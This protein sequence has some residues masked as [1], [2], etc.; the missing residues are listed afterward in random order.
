MTDATNSA[1]EVDAVRQLRGVVLDIEQRFNARIQTLEDEND[2]LRRRGTVMVVGVAVLLGLAT[3]LVVAGRSGFGGRAADVVAA[4]SFVLR[5][6]LGAT[7]GVWGLDKAGALRLTLQSDSG[8]G[9]ISL[10]LLKDGAS[11]LSLTDRNSRPRV[12]LGVLPDETT[13][14]TLA[15]GEG[16]TRTVLGLHPSGASTLVFADRGGTTR[17]GLGVDGRGVGT[18]TMDDRGAASA[19]AVQEQ[20]SEAAPAP[21]QTE[22]ATPAKPAK[23]AAKHKP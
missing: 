5:D 16:V 13:T 6:S 21:A 4:Q 10:M 3:A 8:K 11:G 22:A 19:Q 7:R 1:A 2:K 18:L 12:V 9:G 23:P 14:L 20:P 15:D 17:A